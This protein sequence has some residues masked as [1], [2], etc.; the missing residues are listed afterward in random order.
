MEHLV[1]ILK[2][3]EY[4]S[5]RRKKNVNEKQ[6]KERNKSKHTLFSHLFL[7]NSRELKGLSVSVSQ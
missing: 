4:G 6:E 2:Q 7:E 5:A 3:V 1:K